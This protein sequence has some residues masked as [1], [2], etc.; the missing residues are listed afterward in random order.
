MFEA[1]DLIDETNVIDIYTERK[2]VCFVLNNG[3]VV[4]LEPNKVP[5][6]GNMESKG[7]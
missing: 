6:K 7:A 5:V 3:F 1:K 4:K 2:Y